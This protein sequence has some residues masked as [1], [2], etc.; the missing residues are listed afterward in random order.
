M[1]SP[2]YDSLSVELSK[3]LDDAVATA[4][5]SGDVW[6]TTQRDIPL[7]DACK[8]LMAKYAAQIEAEGEM[9]PA[10]DFFRSLLNS[11]GQA[12][13]S[14][15][16]ALSSYT[17]GV[18]KIISVLNGT[19]VVKPL[20]QDWIDDIADIPWYDAATTNQYYY[21]QAG[22]LINTGGAATDTMTLRYIKN[23]SNLT[24]SNATD[25]PIPSRYFQEILD[26]ATK[27]AIGEMGVLTKVT[28]G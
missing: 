20:P 17:G 15:S 27:Y 28:A 22:N 14:N 18:F 6:S 23:W 1:A 11:E 16:I 24:A 4:S 21:I 25:I 2:N 12:M 5:T 10:W 19:T 26:V 9:S 13:T 8:Q 3:R 7:N